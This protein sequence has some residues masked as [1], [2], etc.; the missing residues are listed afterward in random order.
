MNAQAVRDDLALLGGVVAHPVEQWRRS[1]DLAV[2]LF[3]DGG[4]TINTPEAAL[5]EPIVLSTVIQA[6]GDVL[7]FLDDEAVDPGLLETHR[8]QVGQWYERSRATVRQASVAVQAVGVAVAAAP[9]FTSGWISHRYVSWLG[10]TVVSAV[11]LPLSGWLLGLVTRMA[12]RRRI[13]A[14]LRQVGA[15]G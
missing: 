3:R 9:T 12:F 14:V 11:V 10:A 4:A 1:R 7:C 6:D 5:D 8:Q 15:S 2:V 13:D